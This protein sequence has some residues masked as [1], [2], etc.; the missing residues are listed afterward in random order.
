MRNTVPK[1]S[2][3]TLT[4]VKFHS[5]DTI[6]LYA[7]TRDFFFLLLLLNTLLLVTWMCSV[8]IG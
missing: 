3:F 4:L 1:K 8:D 2:T 6:M 7:I 5:E